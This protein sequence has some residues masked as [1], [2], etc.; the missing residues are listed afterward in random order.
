[1]PLARRTLLGLPALLFA[2][3]LPPIARAQSTGPLK[4]PTA[5]MA[6]TAE[7]KADMWKRLPDFPLWTA[8]DQEYRF[9]Q[10]L[11]RITF[12]HFWGSWCGPCQRE[13][14]QM[15]A[16]YK[17]FKDHPDMNRLLVVYGEPFA[18]GRKYLGGSIDDAALFDPREGGQLGNK[19]NLYRQLSLRRVP[20][21]IITDRNGLVIFWMEDATDWQRIE[22]EMPNIFANSA[23]YTGS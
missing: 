3:S 20:G 12:L 17:K 13:M 9:R 10:S 18:S 21:T 5:E 15:T 8:D 14:P 16:F 23:P 6:R 22:R 7:V 19:Q 11:G 2:A 1:M 4:F